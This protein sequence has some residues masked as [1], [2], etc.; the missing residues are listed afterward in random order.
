MRKY[1]LWLCL[2]ALS[3]CYAEDKTGSRIVFIDGVQLTAGNYTIVLPEKPTLQEKRSAEEL[4]KYLL[5]MTG[6][7]ISVISGSL[8]ESG[9]KGLFIGR[10]EVQ[11]QPPFSELGNDGIG[12]FSVPQGVVLQG[13]LRGCLYSMYTFLQDY[14]DCRWYTKDCVVVPQ[15]GGKKIAQLAHRYKPAILFRGLD[16]PNSRDADFGVPNKLNDIHMQ[17]SDPAWG[18]H[19][20]FDRGIGYVHTFGTLVN[21]DKYFK[22]HPEYYSLRNGKRVPATPY[23]GQLCL[24]NPDVLRIAVEYIMENLRR[25]PDIK[26][27][28]VS[29]NDNMNFCTCK[30]CTDLA[31]SEGSQAGP[32][33]HFVNGIAAAVSKKYP[34]TM[35]QT[36]AYT[37]SRKPPKKVKPHDNVI[38]QLCSIECCF[39]HTFAK[40]PHNRIFMRD[41]RKWSRVCKNMSV[42]NYLFNW[43]HNMQ[44]FPN[45]DA[46]APDIRT[47]AEH[48]VRVLYCQQAYYEPISEFAS[49]RTY[50]LARTMWD[51]SCDTWQLINEFCNAYYGKASSMIQQYLK[52]LHK[53]TA[54]NNKHMNSGEARSY[55]YFPDFWEKMDKLF[56]MA[57][58]AVAA[59][60]VL[61]RR[62]QIEHMAVYYTLATLDPQSSAAVPARDKFL[63]YARAVGLKY[64]GETDSRLLSVWEKNTARKIIVPSAKL[65]KLPGKPVIDG[66]LDTI[67]KNA[68]TLP[69][70]DSSG[71]LP[72][73]L[74]AAE[75]KVGY[76]DDAL[77]VV[78]SCRR[79]M[80]FT[81]AAKIAMHDDLKLF[82]C[83]DVFEIFISNANSSDHVHFAFNAQNKRFDA[84]NT[85]LPELFNPQWKSAA[86]DQGSHTVFEAEIPF[87]ELGFEGPDMVG[88]A[89]V[90][91]LKVNFGREL[92]AP[93][94]ELQM[95]NPPGFHNVNSFGKLHFQK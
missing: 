91:T 54:G 33:I 67:Y 73:P 13:N 71:N 6:E 9:R 80:Q 27:V 66:Q 57:E 89:V 65:P 69:L 50:V 58:A 20:E 39:S 47:L 76:T 85:S 42:W 31:E 44:P 53:L 83:G 46:I 28:C 18:G 24:T 11:G 30:S 48:N 5:K 22:A 92:Y 2:L 81:D 63:Q 59:D 64:V 82:T 86:S 94:Q 75:V 17:W 29:Q 26:L 62:V 32:I 10:F 49:L 61:L 36:I 34:E 72:A 12:I 4:Q 25:N 84:R 37:Y 15:T 23:D 40:C 8:P 74:R 43:H 51:P 14:L 1:F 87:K 41:L 35:I 21:P 68:L 7:K 38:V 60:P 78:A 3:L 93:A 55:L 56:D 95:W 16:D 19:Q 90:K 70:V 45:F 88:P 52:E 77:Y 79:D